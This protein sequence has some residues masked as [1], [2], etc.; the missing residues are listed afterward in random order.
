MENE[1]DANE[2]LGII[3]DLPFFRKSIF[4]NYNVVNELDTSEE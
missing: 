1:W 3:M 2:I 4:E